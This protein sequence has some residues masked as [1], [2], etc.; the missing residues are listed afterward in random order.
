VHVPCVTFPGSIFTTYHYPSTPQNMSQ[1]PDL[2]IFNKAPP[3]RHSITNTLNMPQKPP[4]P[5][6]NQSQAIHNNESNFPLFP[7]LPKELRLN[8]WQH[9]LRRNRIIKVF[10]Q[11]EKLFDNIQQHT[12]QTTD[13]I[14]STSKTER[15]RAYVNGYQTI[16]KLFRVNSEAREVASSFYRVP[17]PCW[18][19]LGE[20]YAG[21]PTETVPGPYAGFASERTGTL[22]FNPEYDFLHISPEIWVKDTLVDFLY[23]LRT[24]YD[25]HHVGLLNL[26]VDINGLHSNDLSQLEPSALDPRAR[27]AFTES[28]AQI[29]E[30]FF[31]CEQAVGRQIHRAWGFPSHE[32]FFNRSF[33]IQ[34]V[35]ILFLV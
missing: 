35:S 8:I 17:I 27:A 31:V 33:P 28:L 13:S 24:I 19:K 14:A 20:T 15:Y 30:I 16:S 7:L 6:F 18:L 2:H 25:L 4:L 34:G 12:T 23:H 10:L 3:S 22:Y 26:A 1:N 21:F 11:A 32:P 29:R 9:S 5:I